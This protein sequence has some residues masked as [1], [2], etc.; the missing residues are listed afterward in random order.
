[1]CRGSNLHLAQ[2]D[3]GGQAGGDVRADHPHRAHLPRLLLLGAGGVTRLL[4]MYKEN[5]LGIERSV[6]ETGW[7]IVMKRRMLRILRR[8]LFKICR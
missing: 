2:G 1:M 7:S 4:S 3:R 8:K 5:M 6:R